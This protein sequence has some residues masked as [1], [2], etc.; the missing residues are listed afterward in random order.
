MV[1]RRLL[2]KHPEFQADANEIAKGILVEVKR[3]EVAEAV[4]SALE[5]VSTGDVAAR[6]GRQRGHG[7]VDPSE[8]AW[9]LLNAAVDPYRVRLRRLV[10]VGLPDAAIECG[11][12]ILRGL[13]EGRGDDECAIFFEANFA[14][15]T[16]DAVLAEMEDVGLD[17]VSLG[18]TD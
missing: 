11:A 18:D 14:A 12:G 6:S 8:A 16:A 4:R 13:D 9:E 3:D 1:V 5:A 15:E 17:V 2:G 7:Y 10:E